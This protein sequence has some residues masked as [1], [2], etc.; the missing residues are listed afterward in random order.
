MTLT[1]GARNFIIAL[2]IAITYFLAAQIGFQFAFIA[3]QV[4]TVW[5]PSGIGIAALLL[6]GRQMWPAVWLG[7]FLAN[8]GAEA[9]MWTAV[10]VAT[11]NT[12]EAVTAAWLLRRVPH[13]D[14]R[15]R[16]VQDA[17]AFIVFGALVSTMVSATIGVTTLCAAGVQPW[18]SYAPLWREW[19]LGDAV[20]MMIVGPSILTLAE[21]R[22]WTSRQWS[23]AS[24]LVGGA[25]LTTYLIFGQFLGLAAAHPLEYVV[26]PFVIAAAMRTTQPTT[27]FAVLISSAISIWHT[28]RGAGPFADPEIH[29]SL[30]LLQ[31]FM[32]ILG[33]TAL[34]LSATTEERRT[35]DRRRAAAHS[36][37]EILSSAPDLNEAAP[38]IV[39][40]MCEHLNWQVGG[41]WLIDADVQR[42]RCLA[43]WTEERTDAPAFVAATRSM[44]FEKRIGLPGRV[45][46]S[47]KAAWIE[48][49]VLDPNFPRASLAQE[50]GLHGAFG[51][52]ICLS[53]EVLGVIE[54]FNWRI[55]PPDD[56]MLKTMSVVGNQIGQYMGRIRELKNRSQ[57]ERDREDLLVREARARAEA[58]GAN[59]AKDEFLATLSHE[60]RTPLNAIVGW[61]RL[62]LDGR[63][64]EQSTKRALEVVDRNAQL[65][66]QLI[67][68]IL[69][70][71]RIITGG[72]RL[73]LRPVDLETVVGS[74]LDAVGPAAQAK[75]VRLISRL[76]ASNRLV[77]GDPKRLQQV[78]WNLLS[79]AVKFTPSDGT[80]I[81]E[82]LDGRDG[83]VSI[84]VVDSGMGIDAAFL[85]NVFDRFRQA[86]GSVSRR[87]G[88]LGLGLAIVR[89]LVELHGGTVHAASDGAERGSTF[90][91]SLRALVEA[92]SADQS[93]TPA[94]GIARSEVFAPL[95]GY[96]LLAIDDHQDTRELM[97]AILTAAGAVVETF[98]SVADGL[99]RLEV[100]QP[101]AVLADIG[102]PGADGYDLIRELRRRDA[103][104]GSRLPVAAITA[105]V[106]EEDRR[107]I[108]AAGFDSHVPKPFDATI[109]VAAVLAIC[110]A[111]GAAREAP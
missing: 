95:R 102:M 104:N 103:G 22:R 59:R 2:A 89:H 33:G 46:S 40:T 105:Y 36:V 99:R 1:R 96:Q 80:V 106:S 110:P 60:L 14:Y 26:F 17:L 5:A 61:T 41:L 84:R 54:C 91:V 53:D 16:R 48:N 93:R 24:L 11:G 32:G 75:N 58:E 66:A 65:Q 57:A 55:L 69:D 56:D 25:A 82:I 37:G 19:W 67:A 73:D 7:A 31:A 111:A 100:L 50:A 62:L 10:V 20:G 63:L 85:P 70:V 43:V 94:V 42:L 12:L 3:A 21:Q 68:D 51:F 18:S 76:T 79:N 8:A 6:N 9:P 23:E 35:G 90:T 15:L 77:L 47:G 107:R 83:T 78:V 4:T 74:A 109:L 92:P 38:A 88:G 13:F 108:L 34:I 87:H 39:R 27:A 72:L 29:E 71:S 28:V 101:D 30:V 81:V 52:P 86:D 98:A 49:V 44:L 97:V 45:W 64:D